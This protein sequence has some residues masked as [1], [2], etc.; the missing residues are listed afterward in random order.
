ML[1]QERLKELLEYNPETGV[2]TWLNKPC[3][4][5]ES[6]KVAGTNIDG[7]ILI[8]IDYKKYLAH[9]LVWFYVY[10]Y[11][12]EEIDH[13]NHV[14]D[15][16]KIANLREVTGK[17][18]KKNL[19]LQSNNTSGVTGV[20]RHKHSDRWQSSIKVNRKTIFLGYHRGLF[21]AVA[22]RKSAELKHGFHENHGKLLGNEV[23]APNL[24][25]E[26]G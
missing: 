21:E 9:R 26:A 1:T 19:S 11:W 22:V 20:S 18:N 7:Y 24:E 25:G 5:M 17:E 10:G 6:G 12:P 13:K 3:K 15:D 4:N 2:F 14:R 8:S 23:A 16:N